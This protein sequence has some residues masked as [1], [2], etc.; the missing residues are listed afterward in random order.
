MSRI[1]GAKNDISKNIGDDKLNLLQNNKA[2]PAIAWLLKITSKQWCAKSA[3]GQEIFACYL[4][5][6]ISMKYCGR[7]QG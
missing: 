6:K 1:Q 7:K 3:Y 5:M 4:K 2:L